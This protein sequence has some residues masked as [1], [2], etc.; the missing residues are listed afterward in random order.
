MSRGFVAVFVVLG[1]AAAGTFA[2]VAAAST[3]GVAPENAV[4][5]AAREPV[6]KT[7]S[8][9]GP[10]A[11]AP[12][13]RRVITLPPSIRIAG[14]R[15]GRLA[16]TRAERVVQTAFNKP[17]TVVVNKLRLRVDPAKL[18]TPYVAGA[19]GHA[20][21]AKPGTSLPLVVA[22]KGAAVR[23][24]AKR[25][26]SRIDRRPA[27]DGLTLRDGRPYVAPRAFG[28]R[29]D[30]GELVQRVVRALAANTRLPV[31]VTTSRLQPRSLASAPSAVIVINRSENILRLFKGTKPWRTFRVATGQAAYPT[32]RGRFDIVVRWKD[33]WWYPPASP[34]AVGATPVPP[35]PG[36]PLGTRWMGLSAPGVGIHGTPKPES[37]GY[38]ESHGCIRMLIPQ[39][40][41]LFEH[42]EVGTTVFVI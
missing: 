3:T 2:A 13:A 27:K 36:N 31:H 29:L 24:W 33:P 7:M 16:P 21:S 6:S 5:K 10:H 18:A 30:Q 40:E 20:R 34:W 14:V 32:P 41:W 37:I 23:A 4:G 39:A 28:R 25:L 26:A 8:T 11:A 22:V 38:S 12:A 42:V 17:L 1:L 9:R 15:V 35:G 19:V